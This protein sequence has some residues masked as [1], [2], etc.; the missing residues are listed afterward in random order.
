MQVRINLLKTSHFLLREEVK[1]VKEG[2]VFMRTD[3][4]RNAFGC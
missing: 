1:E 3:S 4:H 2:N